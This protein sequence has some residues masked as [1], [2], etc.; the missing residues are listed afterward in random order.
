MPLPTPPALVH[1]HLGL[2]TVCKECSVTSPNPFVVVLALCPNG[3]SH[4]DDDVEE[5]WLVLDVVLQRVIRALVV[6]SATT[7]V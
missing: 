2:S 5:L 4:D 3:L 1:S 6:P 7:L